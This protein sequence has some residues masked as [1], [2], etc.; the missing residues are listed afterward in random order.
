MNGNM[1]KTIS[2]DIVQCNILELRDQN[3]LARIS[4]HTN[5]EGTP[6][7]VI[8]SPRSKSKFSLA[9]EEDGGLSITRVAQDGTKS[10][11]VKVPETPAPAQTGAP[12]EGG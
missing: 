9:F 8:T 6:T 10:E 1:P 7:V 2:A 3:G 12:A 4:A 5:E 11:V